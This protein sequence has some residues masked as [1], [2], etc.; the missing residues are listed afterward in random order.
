MPAQVSGKTL[1]FV[2]T[3]IHSFCF[4]LRYFNELQF[5][6]IYVV[7]FLVMCSLLNAHVNFK[8]W[9]ANRN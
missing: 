4:F 8:Q 2:D 1:L 9:T 6:R 7:F 3:V 5:R